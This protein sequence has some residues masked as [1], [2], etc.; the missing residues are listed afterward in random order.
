MAKTYS[1]AE[2]AAKPAFNTDAKTLRIFLRADAKAQGYEAPGKGS[3]WAIEGR[4]INSLRGRFNAWSRAQ[5]EAKAKRAEANAKAQE[6]AE[7]DAA[8]DEAEDIAEELEPTEAELEA[9]TDDEGEE[10]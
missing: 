6:A 2:L 7:A 3:K 10:G 9:M 4:E 1:P 8:A 5:A